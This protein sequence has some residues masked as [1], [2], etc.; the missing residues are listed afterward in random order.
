MNP[1][2][3]TSVLLV[4]SAYSP[5]FVILI[6]KDFDFENT[7]CFN[8]PYVIMVIFSL[9]VLSNALLC[10]CIH[11]FNKGNK[12]VKV[13]STKKRSIDLINYTIPYI[14]PFVGVDLSTW[15]DIISLIIFLSMMMIL[16]IRSQSV[17]MNPVLLM[18]G[19]NLYDIEYLFNGKSDHATVLS[20]HKLDT[21]NLC[22]IISVSEDLDLH[23]VK[24]WRAK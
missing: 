10:V 18:I 3:F 20:K 11:L 13:T 12:E 15:G 2:L 5:L 14:I 21:G 19:Y 22:H 23:L 7:R 8:H 1:R 24:K 6:V 16:T 9:V 17:F 4:I